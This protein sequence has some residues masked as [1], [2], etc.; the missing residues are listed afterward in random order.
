[1]VVHRNALKQRNKPF[2]GSTKS[3]PLKKVKITAK[4]ELVRIP[5]K[6]VI[7]D[8]KKAA[9][10]SR[11][12]VKRLGPKAILI[13]SCNSTVKS[14]DFVN[15]ITQYIQG[16]ILDTDFNII[17]DCDSIS[18][19]EWN[20]GNI[21][22]L[23]KKALTSS[24]SQKV[25]FYSCPRNVTSVLSAAAVADIIILLFDG[26]RDDDAFD[27]QGYDIMR[28]LKLQG[29][30]SVIGVNLTSSDSSIVKRYFNDELGP[31]KKYFVLKD[32]LQL[33]RGISSTSCKQISW[34]KDRGYMLGQLHSY[35]KD[36][37]KLVLKG[38]MKNLGFTCKNLVHITDVGDFVLD[39]I[40]VIPP[41]GNT[42]SLD[43][44]TL[45]EVNQMDINDQI[46]VLNEVIEEDNEFECQKLDEMFDNI[47]IESN[48]N[49]VLD[50]YFKKIVNESK[51][52]EMEIRDPKDRMFPDEVDIPSNILASKRFRKYRALE[53]FNRSEWDPYM[54]LPV[55]YSKI[56]EFESFKALVKYCNS[57]HSKHASKIVEAIKN[58][59][60]I[61]TNEPFVYLQIS[62]VNSAIVDKFIN[63]AKPFIVST[64]LPYERKVTVLE[65]SINKVAPLMPIESHDS[66][67]SIDSIPSKSEYKF[68]TGF[69]RFISRPIFSIK[70]SVNSSGKS[71]YL[72]VLDNT[73]MCIASIYGFALPLSNPIIMMRNDEVIA[74]GSIIGPNPKRVVLKRII[75][76]GY[77]IKVHKQKAIVRYMFFNPHDIRWY[78]PA[79]LVTKRG[80]TGRIMTSLGTHGYM[81]C[82]FDQYISQDDVVMLYLYKRVYPKWHPYTWTHQSITSSIYA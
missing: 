63:D 33:L 70:T 79:K 57:H 3:N 55:P 68:L 77:P 19:S 61:D 51:N 32:T 49:D 67:S 72:K 18:D 37:Q 41:S 39:K 17:C 21:V 2:K 28:A 10:Q 24:F 40:E 15:K 16:T 9:K 23:P 78:K 45:D 11:L 7:S 27:K 4:V 26:L 44:I 34:R 47:A 81:K 31:D 36:D 8:T 64:V 74:H 69:R 6:K 38:Y 58:V 29:M 13:V 54:D 35:N 50:E 1:M 43:P 20:I 5:R 30:P 14:S 12:E 25:Y 71:I 59:T 75:L 46:D 66:E 76:T 22:Q 62:G 82:L 65:M 56:H 53:D 52:Y 80:L 42:M 73:K 60:G 48:D